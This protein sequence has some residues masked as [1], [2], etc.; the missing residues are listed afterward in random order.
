M[1]TKAQIHQNSE[2]SKLGRLDCRH[3]LLGSFLIPIVQGGLAQYVA[4]DSM[5]RH[6]TKANIAI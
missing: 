6:K 3:I 1:H 2:K 4:P 5:A